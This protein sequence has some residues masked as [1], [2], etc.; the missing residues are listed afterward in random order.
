MFP[1]KVINRLGNAQPWYRQVQHPQMLKRHLQRVL[2]PTGKQH[3]QQEIQINNVD[4]MVG[5]L[6]E[7]SYRYILCIQYVYTY[8]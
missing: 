2:P 6:T 8:N 3:K 5:S 1:S 7:N 4:T